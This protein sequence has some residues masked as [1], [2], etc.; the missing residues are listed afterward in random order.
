MTGRPPSGM[1]TSWTVGTLRS[2]LAGIPDDT[3]LVISAADVDDPDFAIEQVI[4]GAGFGT[5]DCGD[6]YGPEQSKVFGLGCAIPEGPIE[7]RSG[8]PARA[9]IARDLL[10]GGGRSGHSRESSP[11]PDW[12]LEAEP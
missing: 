3:P 2:A 1:C 7:L 8:R 4:T 10:A 5:I 9:L 6:G 12:Q 11:Q